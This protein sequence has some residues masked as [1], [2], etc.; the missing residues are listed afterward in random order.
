MRRLDGELTALRKRQLR[1]VESGLDLATL[2]LSSTLLSDSRSTLPYLHLFN[3]VKPYFEGKTD[4][5]CV[6]PFHFHFCADHHVVGSVSTS[7]NLDVPAS[8]ITSPNDPVLD[9]T[10][11][12]EEMAELK[13]MRT[14]STGVLEGQPA[15]SKWQSLFKMFQEWK[16]ETN[17]AQGQY[18]LNN[19]TSSMLEEEIIKIRAAIVSLQQKKSLPPS[20]QQLQTQLQQRLQHLMRVQRTLANV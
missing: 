10:L 19:S 5:L 11:T 9:D 14:E 17:I 20:E 6:S 12:E 7:I 13:L 18:A 1:E 16:R 2:G 8:T 4:H 3:A 15:K